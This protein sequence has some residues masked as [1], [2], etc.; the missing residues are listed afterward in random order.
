MKN[1][2]II[3]RTILFIIIIALLGFAIVWVLPLFKNWNKPLAPGLDLPTFTANPNLI[4][5]Q[6]QTTNNAKP[7][8]I[9]AKNSDQKELITDTSTE[10]ETD[11]KSTPEIIKNPIDAT[12]TPSP[13]CGG[14]ETMMV[15]A[16]GIDTRAD[17]YLYGL[18]DVIRLVRVDFVTPKVT[19]LSMPRD[20]WVEIPEIADNYGI[21][22]GK[23]NQ[24]YFYGT[25][26]M[27]Y[28]HGPG[29]A[30]GLMAR[31]LA[32]N[33][34]VHVDH[35]GTV[36]MLTFEKMV[37]ALGGIDLYLPYDVDGRP[38]DDK[39]EDMGF[40]PAGHHHFNG[41]QALRFSRIRKVDT[42]FDRMDRQTMVLCALKDKLNS[43]SVFPRI[44]KLIASFQDSLITDLSPAQISELACLLPKLSRENIIFTSIPKEILK[45]GR[46]YDE[47]RQN[48]TF[49]WE[50]DY[51][52]IRD[53]I[54]QFQAGTWPDQPKEP[55]CP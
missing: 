7:T 16:L 22:E 17:N 47:H 28:Y 26:G 1:K 30:P 39:T 41:D 48:T 25:E 21:T 40:F 23:L 43:P 2:K 50:A 45:P 3:Y 38:V 24:S 32:L 10:Q 6:S 55:S 44:P 52:I 19:V 46:A 27:G 15:L 36:N 49:I 34:G 8:D 18:A 20:L 29:G 42:V 51:N 35:Y 13:Y 12:E 14:P 37:N 31:T 4:S 53:L 33:F 11:I 9:S 5:T 54:S